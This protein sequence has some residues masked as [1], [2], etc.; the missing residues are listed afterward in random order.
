MLNMSVV[1]YFIKLLF[2]FLTIYLNSLDCFYLISFFKRIF[3]VLLKNAPPKFKF[4]P[5]FLGAVL[6]LFKNIDTIYFRHVS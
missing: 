5:M 1:I 3:I 4:E 2:R 6:N